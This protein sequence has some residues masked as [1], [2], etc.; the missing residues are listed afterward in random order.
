[1]IDRNGRLVASA[2]RETETQLRNDWPVIGSA[3]SGKP[4]TE[5]DIFENAD[6]EK[7]SPSLAKRARLGLV[8]TPNAMPTERTEEVRGMVVQG[9]SLVVLSN[10]DDAVLVGGILLN[11]NLVF[12]DTINDLFIHTQPAH[13][14]KMEGQ[15]LE[16]EQ[17]NI[18]RATYLRRRLQTGPQ[19]NN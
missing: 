10:A 19:S 1:M 5:I 8:P 18:A 7:L 15:P 16:S 4:S 9:A 6:L 11:Q 17:R 12:I 13:L 14:Q 2:A 3:L